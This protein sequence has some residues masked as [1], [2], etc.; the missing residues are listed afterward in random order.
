MKY[1]IIPAFRIAAFLFIV[2][3]C[4][5][6][7]FILCC[8]DS[9][10]HFEIRFDMV[11]AN[12][13]EHEDDNEHWCYKTAIDWVT[14]TKTPIK[15]EDTPAYKDAKALYESEKRRIYEKYRSPPI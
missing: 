2:I 6:I 10:W 4:Y 15:D 8:I 9:L 13:F 12:F 7:I 1:V 3:F 5:P 14:G 11:K